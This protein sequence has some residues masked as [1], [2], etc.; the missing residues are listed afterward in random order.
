MAD[1]GFGVGSFLLRVFLASVLVF[2]TYN[3][4]HYSYFHWV[5]AGFDTWIPLKAFV[6]II[7]IIG[8]AIFIRATIR[9]LGLIGVILA[10]AFFVITTW[11]I[12]D[13]IPALLSIDALIYLL[14]VVMSLILATG[15]SWS[16]IRRRLTGQMDVDELEE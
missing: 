6:G 1:T 4:T 8:W 11:V 9:S 16:H 3:P 12:V 15:M 2:G 10:S 7:I 13:L 14:L 5:I